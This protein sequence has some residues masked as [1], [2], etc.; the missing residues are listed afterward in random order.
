MS[1]IDTC[2]EQ[3]RYIDPK[4]REWEKRE[5]AK[6]KAR[7][8]LDTCRDDPA[9]VI[10]EVA[11]PGEKVVPKGEFREVSWKLQDLLK[12]LDAAADAP[13][14]GRVKVRDV[15]SKIEK[16]VDDLEEKYDLT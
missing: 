2:C 7:E 5:I 8:F 9:E 11:H 13:K 3:P 15:I 16:L 4:L 14:G 10:N 12:D 1:D 6:E